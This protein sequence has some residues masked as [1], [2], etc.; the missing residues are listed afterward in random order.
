MLRVSK[1]STS[2]VNRSCSLSS[3]FV[4]G[5]HLGTTMAKRC[6]SNLATPP[7]TK[8]TSFTK[9]VFGT[10]LVG[11]T[12]YTGA[13]YYATLDKQFQ[14]TFT[15]HVPSGKLT[16]EFIE[17]VRDGKDLHGYLD[18]A[19]TLKQQVHT[20]T[21]TGEDY[22][23]Q[24]KEKTYAAYLS[25]AGFSS[26]SSTSSFSATPSTP[27]TKP[28]PSD[29]IIAVTGNEKAEVISITSDKQAVQP[30]VHV[31]IEQPPPIRVSRLTTNNPALH[32]LSS[33]IVEL[34]SLLNKAGLASK[35][36]H[37]IGQAEQ[38]LVSLSETLQAFTTVQSTVSSNLGLLQNEAQTTEASL[39]E[40]H[41]T[42]EKDMIFTEMVTRDKLNALEITLRE[43]AER[44]LAEL[45]ETARCLLEERKNKDKENAAKERVYALED[46]ARG[47][48]EQ[49]EKAEGYLVEIERSGRL[50][51]LEKVKYRLEALQGLAMSSTEA[52][53]SA[54][55]AHTM[56]A[57]LVVARSDM[58]TK[59]V[60]KKLKDRF[61]SVT[62]EARRV[63]LVP[64]DGGFGAHIVSRMMSK[65]LFKKT[66]LVEGEDVESVLSRT[67]Y[68]LK[69]GDLDMA[70]RE[71]NQLKGWP[72]VLAMDWLHEARAHLVDKQRLEILEE[73]FI[74][75]AITQCS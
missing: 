38:E 47:M 68:Y 54:R 17:D 73:T 19:N 14:H 3:S 64:L 15:T 4:Y 45:K 18:Q 30:I 37:V 22:L 34:A 71:L 51:R 5:K 69:K 67:G 28:V 13:A 7:P 26:T 56:Y 12:A 59:G 31:T 2:G 8:K 39:N 11:I 61:E 1:L 70:V 63:A 9:T 52:L 29:T 58:K 42:A 36:R 60:E 27:S 16:V 53:D 74:S 25:V 10:A 65:L 55:K 43:E 23:H 40:L 44:L 57:D 33:A 41:R 50:A 24:I 66:G 62:D 35:G 20:M 48:E 32:E 46:Q 75:V 21:Q 72:K 6:E 49:Y